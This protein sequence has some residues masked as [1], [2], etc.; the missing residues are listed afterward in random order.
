MAAAAGFAEFLTWSPW[1]ASVGRVGGIIAAIT[2]TMDA[3]IIYGSGRWLRRISDLISLVHVGR[4]GGFIMPPALVRFHGRNAPD[5]MGGTVAQRRAR[6][7]TMGAA[8]T[9]MMARA[10]IYGSGR[11]LRGIS[12]LV[13]LVHFGRSS[14]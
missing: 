3:A 1:Y 13:S 6:T 7:L 11:W 9:L 5:M 8:I 12:D 10:V 2:L 4:S 14:K